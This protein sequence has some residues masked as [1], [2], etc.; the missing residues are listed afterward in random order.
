VLPLGKAVAYNKHTALLLAAAKF[1]A[2]HPS[3]TM[4]ITL[5]NNTQPYRG[6]NVHY[7]AEIV[8]CGGVLIG[9]HGNQAAIHQHMHLRH[10]TINTTQH[11]TVQQPTCRHVDLG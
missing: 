9:R 6:I 3:N 5:N 7:S 4:W 11:N 10:Q 2:K 1:Y 8:D